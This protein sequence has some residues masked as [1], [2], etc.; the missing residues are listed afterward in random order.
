MAK[1]PI[2]KFQDEF[3]DPN[4]NF[5]YPT[6]CLGYAVI[7]N[8]TTKI[9]FIVGTGAPGTDYNNAPLGSLY[10]KTDATPG[11]YQK[12]AASTWTAK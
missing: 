12:T 8:D 10:I 2:L 1:V 5:S 7:G 6:T 4:N 9:H 11:L 3:A